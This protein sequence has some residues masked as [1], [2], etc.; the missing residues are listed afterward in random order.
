MPL[1]PGDRVLIG[2]M[3]LA[4]VAAPSEVAKA[5]DQSVGRTTMNRVPAPVR[6]GAGLP[7]APAPSSDADASTVRRMNAFKLLSEVSE[8]ALAFGRADE[9]ERLLTGPLAEIIEACRSG[10]TLA[11]TLVDSVARLAAKLASAT[12][13][14]KWL[15]YV[16]ELYR[17]QQRPCPALVIDE[18]NGAIR[19][20]NAIDV[21]ALRAYLSLLHAR[22]TSLGPADRFLL[23]RLEG[24]ERQ[25][26]LR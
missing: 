26:A 1:Q 8:K 5:I 23:Q 11:P 12:G 7:I 3:E 13:N 24:F 18:L 17:A 9:A 19:R 21:A 4:L 16:F 2:S 6:A 10:Q 14:G 15:D 22:V 20:V 25:V